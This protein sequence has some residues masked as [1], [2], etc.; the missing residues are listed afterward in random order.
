MTPPPGPRRGLPPAPL[1]RRALL[2]GA[3]A[4]AILLLPA[5]PAAADGVADTVDTDPDVRIVAE[6]AFGW[7]VQEAPDWVEG[8][9]VMYLLACVVQEGCVEL[10]PRLCAGPD[11]S[12]GMVVDA[13]TPLLYVKASFGS[14]GVRAGYSE[15][16]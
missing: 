10:S 6:S 16:C 3:A 7:V 12:A 14:I 9:L 15:R 8:G 13:H 5:G 11:G 1:A 4:L 2:L